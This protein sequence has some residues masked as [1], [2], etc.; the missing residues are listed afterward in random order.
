MNTIF[1]YDLVLISLSDKIIII[2][3]HWKKNFYNFGKNYN[4]VL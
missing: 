3:L 4:T 2:I 1:D